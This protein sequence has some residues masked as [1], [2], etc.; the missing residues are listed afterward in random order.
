MYLSS[1]GKKSL[2]NEW[3]GGVSFFAV[4]PE[5]IPGH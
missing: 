2:S 4:L 1:H 3:E 5:A